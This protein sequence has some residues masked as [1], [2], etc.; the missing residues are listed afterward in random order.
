MKI[1]NEFIYAFVFSTTKCYSKELETFFFISNGFRLQ[2]IHQL[3]RK[4]HTKIV[5]AL[6][7]ILSTFFS[8]CILFEHFVYLININLSIFVAHYLSPVLSFFDQIYVKYFLN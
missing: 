2:E 5:V 8:S 1:I 4:G 7:F 6:Q 3:S